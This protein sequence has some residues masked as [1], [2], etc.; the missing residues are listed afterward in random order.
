MGGNGDVGFK[1]AKRQWLEGL[2][3][4]QQLQGR[5]GRF[6][7]APRAEPVLHQVA[8]Y[9]PRSCW[10][11]CPSPISPTLQPDEH[12]GAAP[13]RAHQPHGWCACEDSRRGVPRSAGGGCKRGRAVRSWWVAGRQLASRWVVAGQWLAIAGLAGVVGTKRVPGLLSRGVTKSLATGSHG[14]HSEQHSFTQRWCWQALRG[15]CCCG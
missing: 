14:A 8:A 3:K 15:A 7:Q 1:P 12:R 11:T 2:K 13:Q 6:A 10:F 4:S 5:S 9:S